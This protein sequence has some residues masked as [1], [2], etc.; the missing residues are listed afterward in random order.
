M[1]FMIWYWWAVACARSTA[2]RAR[3]RRR[4][5]AMAPLSSKDVPTEA[6]RWSSRS[7]ACS[8]GW[9]TRSPPSAFVADA[10]HELRTPLT[11]LQLQ[12]Q[13]TERAHDETERKAALAELRQGC[14][15]RSTWSS[16]CSRWPA[17][18]LTAPLARRARDR[19]AGRCDAQRDGRAC[20]DG[21]CREDRSRATALDDG[22]TVQADP[23]ALRTLLGNLI[24]NAI[25]YTPPD[26][27]STSRYAKPGTCLAEVS[28]TGP[29]IAPT[30][31]ERVLDRFY[32]HPGQGA[33]RQRPRP[34]HRQGHR[35]PPR[36][37]TAARRF[38]LRR[39]AGAGRLQD[40]EGVG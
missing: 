36:R 5:E 2:S 27:W 28:D 23:A 7:T 17:R 3:V 6:S 25:R 4:P 8:A 11:A 39:T 29:G 16:S 13:L 24:D 37:R 21:G 33:A 18:S 12:L 19:I 14:S 9:T 40:G 30:E 20:P 38:G 22:I 32:R 10:A 34:R 31:R 26:G 35:R 1:G 15:G